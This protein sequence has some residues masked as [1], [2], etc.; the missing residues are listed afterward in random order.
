MVKP[1]QTSR[2][3]VVP[4]GS[5]R[6]PR[7]PLR[8]AIIGL[9]WVARDFMLSAIADNP[10]VDLIAVCDLTPPPQG[11]L[12]KGVHHHV[13]LHALLAAERPDAV[14]IATP[15]HLHVQQATAC[16][17]AGI[18]VLC[19]KPIAPTAAEAEVLAKAVRHSGVP[20]ATAFD[21][22]HHP[23]HVRMR[24]MI[25]EGKLGSITQIRLDYAC[26]VP[27]DWSPDAASGGAP[28]PDNW[29]IDRARAGGG[30][31]IDLAPHG[32]DLVET[33]T[34]QRIETLRGMYQ[35]ATHDYE[36][37]DG[38]VLIGALNGGALLVHSVGYNRPE[39]LPRRRLEVIGTK[40]MLEAEDTMGQ[41]AGGRLSFTDAGSGKKGEVDFD[42]ERGPFSE[43]LEAFV[44][45]VRHGGA[46]QR[47][48]SDDLRLAYL[49]ENAF[50][51]AGAATKQPLNQT[52][53]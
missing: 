27:N 34:G 7:P 4:L 35:T 15:N 14:Y 31:V 46:T 39:A 5:G 29:R 37:D 53:N 41:T 17:E 9:G 44:Q 8:L 26:W 18:A 51:D 43:Q 49:L 13:D 12:P 10:D 20:Y 32:L 22:R 24:E 25:A 52:T 36:V 33:I 50:P 48:I 6:T 3:S 21:Q 30:A 1:Q 38:G 23:A 45:L 40:G 2:A 28:A 42:E 47:G 11:V 19:E 16:L